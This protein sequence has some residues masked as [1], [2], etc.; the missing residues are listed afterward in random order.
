[1]CRPTD[2]P[3]YD[4]SLPADWEPLYTG[5]SLVKLE[6]LVDDRPD[7]DHSEDPD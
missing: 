2:A 6:P 3:P 7:R 1:M 4:D 5:P